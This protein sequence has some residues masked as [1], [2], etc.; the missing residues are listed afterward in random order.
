M[1]WTLDI[2]LRFQCSSDIFLRRFL[3]RSSHVIRT[4]LH[5]FGAIRSIGDPRFGA[6]RM[7]EKF[8]TC[9]KKIQELQRTSVDYRLHQRGV[10]ST[11]T[12]TWNAACVSPKCR[13]GPFFLRSR[14]LETHETLS[15][16]PW[17]LRWECC[18]MHFRTF[19]LRAIMYKCHLFCV[20]F[21][22]MKWT[23]W[24][25]SLSNRKIE[26]HNAGTQSESSSERSNVES[27]DEF[28]N[29]P[30]RFQK[31]IQN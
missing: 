6:R 28:E 8:D 12:A 13:P 24:M 25:A 1:L 16:K 26:E 31:P 20:R 3:T 27:S 4:F 19:G 17:L 22:L 11:P 10:T 30:G 14:L 5:S 29:Y 21:G 23:R 15:I 9:Y 18:K 7:E 2:L